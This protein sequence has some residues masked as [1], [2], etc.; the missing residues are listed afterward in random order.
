MIASLV[1]LTCAHYAQYAHLVATVH[2]MNK[3]FIS[4]GFGSHPLTRYGLTKFWQA[5]TM[6]GKVRKQEQLPL[7]IRRVTL[8][9]N[10]DNSGLGVQNLI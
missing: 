5:R 4:G 10:N 7:K 6:F 9:D 2:N 3:V 1:Q 8:Y